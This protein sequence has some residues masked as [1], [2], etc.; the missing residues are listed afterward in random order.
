MVYIYTPTFTINF[1]QHGSYGIKFDPPQNGSHLMTPA[2]LRLLQLTFCTL[3]KV[4]T[5]EKDF[6]STFH[7][8]SQWNPR[9]IGEIYTHLANGP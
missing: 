6:Y 8:W 9:R 3:L 1:S 5:S 2:K 7:S 4:L